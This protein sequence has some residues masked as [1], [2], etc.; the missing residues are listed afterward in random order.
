MKLNPDCLR[1]ILIYLE[2]NLTIVDGNKFSKV[3]LSTLVEELPSYLEDEIFYS[4]Y[5]LK[6][7]N[8]ISGRFSDAADMHMFVCEI[9]NITWE[10]HEFLNTV[11]PKSIWNATK[12]NASKLG[13]SSIHALFSI[14]KILLN[15]AISN[16]EVVSSIT[17]S[18]LQ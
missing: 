16:P 5:N 13:V 7:V 1:D 2:E 10:G 8:M 9:K 4:V 17:K 15:A 14:A 11:R 12:E 6:E 18:L 3:S